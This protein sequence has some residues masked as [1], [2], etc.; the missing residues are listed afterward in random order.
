MNRNP[1]LPFAYTSYTAEDNSSHL[2]KSL[3]GDSTPSPQ[4]PLLLQ[5]RHNE[6]LRLPS[7]HIHPSQHSNLHEPTQMAE[8][9]LMPSFPVT[10]PVVPVV[11]RRPLL[12][13]PPNLK[14]KM[15]SF[16]EK[17]DVKRRE[18][19]LEESF[20]STPGRNYQEMMGDTS[21]D[22]VVNTSSDTLYPLEGDIGI[23][24]RSVSMPP[25]SPPLNSELMSDFYEEEDSNE[26]DETLLASPTDSK[27]KVPEGKPKPRFV[28]N[29]KQDLNRALSSDA[30][31][32]IDDFNRFKAPAQNQLPSSSTG[33]LE[34]DVRQASLNKARQIL[35]DAFEE[36]V[37]N[38]H[39]ENMDLYDVPNEI[40]DMNHMLIFRRE[41]DF[42][43]M[44]QLYLTG[45]NL[46]EL[47]PSLFE[48]T[49]LNVLGLR[50]NKLERIPSLIEKLSNLN[51][52]TLG[53]NR[54]ETLPYQILDLP[55]LH[56]FRAG[57]NPFISVTDDCQRVEYYNS[58]PNKRLKFIS[59]IR[60]F[61]FGY[62][63]KD[64][65]PSLKNLCLNTIAR[66]DV[67]YQETVNWK[68]C[69][70]KVYHKLIASAITKGR[71]EEHC[72]QCLMIVVEP[73]AEVVEWWDYLNNRDIPFKRQ[74]CS[75]SCI[76]KYKQKAYELTGME[77]VIRHI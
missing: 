5:Q 55:K 43:V 19:G 29:R 35:T 58:D 16:N 2:R 28:N 75:G 54:L 36:S 62:K 22:V 66:Y 44:Y 57:P 1:L 15:D 48:F 33:T 49:K 47:M 31:F 50:Q 18:M 39:L 4:Q 71:F 60:Y 67:T 69:T 21:S 51:E 30:D 40:K 8:A 25:S 68:L 12:K 56:T 38:I 11:R 24:D 52:L 65:L 64:T 6:L 20:F 74:F 13:L 59:P 10:Q 7:H 34:E 9:H 53:T 32:G 41:L 17:D 61:V 26:G 72:S 76:K 27:F 37:T 46:R 63:E 73:F 70:P 45:N 77:D 23:D 14:R 42:P 3:I